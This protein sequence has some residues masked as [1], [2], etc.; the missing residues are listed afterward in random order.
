M[1][2]HYNLVVIFCS[3]EQ[4]LT[5]GKTNKVVMFSGV[6]ARLPSSVGLGVRRTRVVRFVTLK[7]TVI[8]RVTGESQE[9]GPDTPSPVG[10]PGQST[11]HSPLVAYQ[12]GWFRKVMI[13]SFQDCILVYSL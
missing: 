13:P 11:G 12:Y 4:L 10:R 3:K 7:V 6:N 2:F 9:I 8:G 1:I 5:R